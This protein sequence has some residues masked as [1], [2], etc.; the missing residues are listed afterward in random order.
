MGTLR[1]FRALSIFVLAGFISCSDDNS[2]EGY[3]EQ[4]SGEKVNLTIEIIPEGGGEVLPK[5]GT[6]AKGHQ[7]TLRALPNEGYLFSFW[8]GEVTVS[9]PTHLITMD[10]D[11]TIT[12][13]FREAKNN[14]LGPEE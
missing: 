13:V 4:L 10:S 9:G 8:E 2:D 3:F 14:F 1:L 7:M 5:S 12:A 11:K 6:Y